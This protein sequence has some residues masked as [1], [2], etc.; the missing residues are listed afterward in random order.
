MKHRKHFRQ[1]YFDELLERIHDIRTS[2]R[3]FYQKIIDSYAQCSID[4]DKNAEQT[5]LFYQTV[6]NKLELEWAITGKT[7]AE[8]IKTRA[9]AE[10]PNM[11]L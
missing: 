10:K 6:R 4:Y 3:R 9:N 8:L 7:A 5:R 11:G 2:E 1:D